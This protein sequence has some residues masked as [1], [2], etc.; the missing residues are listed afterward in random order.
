MGCQFKLVFYAPD[1]ATANR[2]A[3]AAFAHVDKLNRIFSDYDPDSELSRLSRASPTTKPVEISGPLWSV[4]E[5]SQQLAAASD[6]AFDVTVGPYVRLWRRARRSHELPAAER[7]AQA[8]AAVGYRYLKL[9]LD[10]HTAMLTAPPD[11][12]RFGRHR[13]G[14]HRG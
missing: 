2:A 7:L 12:A 11:G 9:D 6:G 14:L 5:R 8:A 10:A 3:E 4:L 13:H 1:K